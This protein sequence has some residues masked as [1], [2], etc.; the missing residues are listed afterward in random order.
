MNMLRKKLIPKDRKIL[1]EVYDEV[2]FR[3]VASL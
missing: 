2:Y 3:K 1:R